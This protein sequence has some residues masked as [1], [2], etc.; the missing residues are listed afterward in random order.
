[1]GS[2][3]NGPGLQFSVDT[4]ELESRLKELGNL[5]S[6]TAGRIEAVTG[7]F[8]GM[9]SAQAFIKGSVQQ[10]QGFN[11]QIAR[12]SALSSATRTELKAL[13]ETAQ[14]LGR[15]T[16][17]TAIDVAK[18][19]SDLALAGFK[20]EEIVSAM[21]GLLATATAGL[22]NLSDTTKTASQVLRSFHIDS[23]QMNYVAGALTATFTSTN[24]VLSDLDYTMKY[25]GADAH[26]L[27]VSLS[28]LSAAAGILGNVGIRG[29]VA[30]TGVREFIARLGSTL[31]E[32]RNQLTNTR[33]ALKQLGITYKDVSDQAGNLNLVKSVD[34]LEN[35]FKK[36]GMT[37]EEKLRALRP[38]FGAR[39]G[40]QVTALIGQGAEVLQAKQLEV[41]FG[42]VKQ[43]LDGLLEQAM[44]LPD[45]MHGIKVSS[46]EIADNFITIGNQGASNLGRIEA[47]MRDLGLV[48]GFLNTQVGVTREQ[49]KKIDGKVIRS[50]VFVPM[51]E[52]GR[53]TYRTVDTLVRL[54][55]RLAEIGDEAE[56][57]AILEDV[58]GADPA[59][60]EQAIA[61]FSTGGK[62]M[63]EFAN[64]IIR[65]TSALDV[66]K[67]QLNTVTGSLKLMQSAY[68]SMQIQ[69]GAVFSPLARMFAMVA[70]GAFQ[71]VSGTASLSSIIGDFQ[72]NTGG[73]AAQLQDMVEAMTQ[74][75]SAGKVLAAVGVLITASA[76]FAAL[77]AMMTAFSVLASI[78]AVTSAFAAFMA[79]VGAGG[80]ALVVSIGILGRYY[81]SLEDVGSTASGLSSIYGA[82]ALKVRHL[83]SIFAG[84]GH[85]AS[86]M[87][88]RAIKQLRDFGNVSGDLSTLWATI[89]P[90]FAAAFNEALLGNATTAIRNMANAFDSIRATTT[91]INILWATIV[92]TMIYTAMDLLPA[93]L[94]GFSAIGDAIGSYGTLA[95]PSTGVGDLQEAGPKGGIGVSIISNLEYAISG[96]LNSVDLIASLALRLIDA[97]LQ[98]ALVAVAQIVALV[99]GIIAN[100]TQLVVAFLGGIV[101]LIVRVLVIITDIIMNI[102]MIVVR[103]VIATMYYLASSVKALAVSSVR[104][105]IQVIQVTL[106][107]IPLM[108][109]NGFLHIIAM[110]IGFLSKFSVL[111]IRIGAMIITNTINWTVYLF[112]ALLKVTAIIALLPVTLP[113]L[114]YKAFQ[115]LMENITGGVKSGTGA[116]MSV[117][118]NLFNNLWEI[119]TE[120]LNKIKAGAI[121]QLKE[122]V[123]MIFGVLTSIFSLPVIV[124]TII[125]AIYRAVDSALSSIYSVVVGWLDRLPYM[126]AG[127]IMTIWSVI[128]NTISSIISFIG[129]IIS[130]VGRL[131]IRGLST[132]YKIFA[133]IVTELPFLILRIVAHGFQAF[134]SGFLSTITLAM[135][136]IKGIVY[137]LIANFRL[138]FVMQIERTFNIIRYGI[139]NMLDMIQTTAKTAMVRFAEIVKDIVVN[140]PNWL[141]GSIV[142]LANYLR[143][144]VI[145]LPQ[146]LVD[147]TINALNSAFD[148]IMDV[149]F[150]LLF[151]LFDIADGTMASAQSSLVAAA[152]G[153]IT[154]FPGLMIEA[155]ADA[156]KS[157]RDG[158]SALYDRIKAVDWATLGD[159]FIEVLGQIFDNIIASLEQIVNT[160]VGIATGG[161]D[162]FADAVSN[163][164]NF[165]KLEESFGGEI[166]T[167][168]DNFA[169]KVLNLWSGFISKLQGL[170]TL[171]LSINWWN[172]ILKVLA[173]VYN[174]I[175]DGVSFLRQKVNSLPS[176]AVGDVVKR[177]INGI[178]DIVVAGVRIAAQIM[179]VIRDNWGRLMDSLRQ[180]A[181]S[182]IGFGLKFVIG[183]FSLL[184]GVLFMLGKIVWSAIGAIAEITGV[185]GD[186]GIEAAASSGNFKLLAERMIDGF[187]LL[188]NG[189]YSNLALIIGKIILQVALMAT[190]FIVLAFVGVF[191]AIE[192]AIIKQ[193]PALGSIVSVAMRGTMYIVGAMTT[194]FALLAVAIL[195]CITV[196]LSPLI[197]AFYLIPNII[198]A[199]I[200]FL[201]D[202][203]VG[204]AKLA[205]WFASGFTDPIG[206][207]KR[208]FNSI[209]ESIK[210]FFGL[211][212]SIQETIKGIIDSV[213]EGVIN[214]GNRIGAYI[215][216]WI[217]SWMRGSGGGGATTEFAEGGVI[218]RPTM[219]SPTIR[220]GESGD[221]AV[222]PLQRASG[223]KLGVTL[224]GGGGGGDSEILVAMASYV[225]QT[226]REAAAT[227]ITA[228]QAEFYA[229]VDAIASAMRASFG[230]IASAIRTGVQVIVTAVAV[231]A[232]IIS[233]I[234]VGIGSIIAVGTA[235]VL[236]IGGIITTAVATTVAA[237]A[238]H[239]FTSAGMIV[240]TIYASA[241]ASTTAIVSAIAVSSVA[242]GGK[243]LAL[244]TAAHGN[245]V[246]ALIGTTNIACRG[247]FRQA[248][249]YFA[250]S[251]ILKSLSGY[252]IGFFGWLASF[253]SVATVVLL[254]KVIAVTAA[255]YSVIG[256]IS[257]LFGGS[258]WGPLKWMGGALKATVDAFFSPIET[259][260]NTVQAIKD[261]IPKTE[262]E[263]PGNWL[264]MDTDAIKLHLAELPEAEQMRF[265][266]NQYVKTATDLT[267]QQY[268]AKNTNLSM[269]EKFMDYEGLSGFFLS[270]LPGYKGKLTSMNENANS[271]IPVL[272]K[273]F[274]KYIE[275]AAEKGFTLHDDGRIERAA[276]SKTIVVDNTRNEQTIQVTQ[277]NTAHRDMAHNV[278]KAIKANSRIAT[279]NGKS[280][281]INPGT[282]SHASRIN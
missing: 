234:Q 53:S 92:E 170:W 69:L 124:T 121:R 148:A 93:L 219:L 25:A 119:A 76:P 48:G 60:L 228:L 7:A 187:D 10:F 203:I 220:G 185:F 85:T 233:L 73:V 226:V 150:D 61:A 184:A 208:T 222:L 91:L 247:F 256:F 9:K 2:L 143:K 252:V 16:E 90:L 176:G 254:A 250:S 126:I 132:V 14:S 257:V 106:V 260:K 94:K 136:Q 125:V 262:T 57:M 193:F 160:I 63:S 158:M 135:M 77:L 249:A 21:P 62:T 96:L 43:Q 45:G 86:E 99:T 259:I 42:G 102:G 26:E 177:T 131:V 31:A 270:F 239:G 155:I 18:G 128:S 266:Q 196:A 167:F 8:M 229:A 72:D 206:A 174:K 115:M 173:V 95:M 65:A 107:Q 113:Y 50:N 12:T 118:K 268:K 88:V 80:V 178:L 81:E 214:T 253:I 280:E 111:M 79:T 32:N 67:K 52:L 164:I 117:V 139:P 103:F 29:T 47:Q 269:T 153:Y 232:S 82:L 189:D 263:K 201:A 200:G 212:K 154:R 223:G 142:D 277:N 251:T 221:E 129:S 49:V 225:V 35:A 245:K 40:T 161:A 37:A 227:M 23:S 100:L 243:E 162:N 159:L 151:G 183:G 98:A 87:W 192:D 204:L 241:A 120:S 236:L 166:E 75:S 275:L 172:I 36:M 264:A 108:F 278:Q 71:A 134:V 66:Q 137:D 261:L 59:V 194:G 38:I 258:F 13:S 127:Y 179:P 123:S 279:D 6:G 44:R 39:A 54:Q 70:A 248:V 130:F 217:P 41:T 195:T 215:Y 182:G 211:D 205:A 11:D 191:Y 224:S 152:I 24:T 267:T 5:F 186:L 19:M 4:R 138:Y 165:E 190:K 28:Q 237:I 110:I 240:G 163:W 64:Q 1:M 213:I 171:L 255:I 242:S 197:L 180:G 144:V 56:K 238:F 207:L 51:E 22:A 58:F 276:V 202:L 116:I 112:T 97:V 235:S 146:M 101:R 78:P 272:Q 17:H 84:P 15:T 282:Y 218:S 168:F 109:L 273:N 157:F 68:E 55:N 156:W 244:I 46:Q 147:E 74:L 133:S 188:A 20:V 83:M 199:I 230:A 210:E 181:T 33:E 27:G 141:A 140:L 169:T 281:P 175:L 145:E 89:K 271:A 105:I 265:L 104:A 274:D 30:G 34:A 231:S 198:I 122:L 216:S 3:P 246:T 114:A 209:V 149:I